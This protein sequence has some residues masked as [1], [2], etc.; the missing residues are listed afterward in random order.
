[1]RGE[2]FIQTQELETSGLCGKRAELCCIISREFSD[3][4]RAHLDAGLDRIGGHALPAGGH[5]DLRR[6]VH[7][8]VNDRRKDWSVGEFQMTTFLVPSPDA[9]NSIPKLAS[10][11]VATNLAGAF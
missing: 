4:A 5:F 8:F 11:N 9:L 1:M 7:F 10:S 6:I 2:H 3:A